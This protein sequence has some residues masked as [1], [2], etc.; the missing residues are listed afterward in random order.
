MTV[1]LGNM[2]NDFNFFQCSE[3]SEIKGIPEEDIE[4]WKKKL[5]DS[6]NGKRMRFISQWFW[7]DIIGNSTTDKII[8]DKK[9]KPIAIYSK[10]IIWYEEDSTIHGLNVKTSLLQNFE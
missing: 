1:K 5:K 8:S 2:I 6:N 9:I 10:N 7:W 4:T 3:K